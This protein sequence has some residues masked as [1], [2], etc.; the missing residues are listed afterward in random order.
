MRFI[1][2]FLTLAFA[3]NHALAQWEVD[4]IVASQ[5]RNSGLLVRR[6]ASDIRVVNKNDIVVAENVVIT[7]LD[8]DCFNR[9]RFCGIVADSII[10]ESLEGKVFDSW[11]KRVRNAKLAFSYTLNN[12]RSNGL[13]MRLSNPIDVAFPMTVELEYKKVSGRIDDFLLWKPV[14]G[15]DVGIQDGSLR[16]SM[17]DTSTISFQSNKIPLNGS[18]VND[19]GLFI[20]IWELTDF[21]AIKKGNSNELP[22]N[23]LPSVKIISKY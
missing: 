8:K 10:K 13:S 15:Y 1:F 9:F 11:G 19:E 6:Y 2:F 22:L 23:V 14:V 5:L 18:Y 21:R 3:C 16:L 12:G 7:F 20:Y 17:V 4:D